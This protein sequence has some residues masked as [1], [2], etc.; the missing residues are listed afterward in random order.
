[1]E[2]TSSTLLL[3]FAVAFLL[4]VTLANYLALP[5]LSAQLKGLNC[6]LPTNT[7]K[8]LAANVLNATTNATKTA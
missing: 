6:T 2:I 3:I 7:L 8:G 5:A 4:G 1:M